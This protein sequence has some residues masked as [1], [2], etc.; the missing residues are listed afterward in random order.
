MK[1]LWL[2]NIPS[3]YRVAFFN[4]LGKLCEL[5]VLFE[6]KSSSERDDSWKNFNIENFT[7]IFLQ[8]IKHGMAEAFCPG[9]LRHISRK[10]YD[11]IVVTNYANPT[12]MLAIAMMKL[13]GIPYIIEG[14]G[15]F[16]GSGKGLKEKFKTWL[17]SD[18][19]QCFSTAVEHDKYYRMYGVSEERIFR[20]PFTSLQ[21]AD[22][23]ETPATQ[24][25]KVVLRKKL[26]I[27]EDKCIVSVGQFIHRKGYDILFEAL[28][29]VD[30]NVG[31]YII[32]GVPTEEYLDQIKRLGLTNVHFVGFKLKA[33]LAEYYQAADAFVL[34]TREDIWGLVINEA[35][36]Y[37]LP[38]IT[39]DRCI[40]GLE[41]VKDGENG[42]IVPVN[43]DKMLTKRLNEML[44]DPDKLCVMGENALK[45]IRKYTIENMA[46]R[47]ME[48]W[49]G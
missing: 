44:A 30:R 40:A 20:Y 34:P 12:G 41:L 49:R 13:K 32:G 3:P 14:D 4:E 37:G 2:A 10:K 5:T 39:T 1:V 29:G 38:V 46:K 16:A 31:C 17:L 15:A 18:A 25:Q 36:A 23:L 6:R 11:K 43:D 8:G 26:G 42:Y 24:E 33:E 35:M 21:A 47:H 27:Q 7:S 19:E 22:V 9:V 28:A 45:T 48:V